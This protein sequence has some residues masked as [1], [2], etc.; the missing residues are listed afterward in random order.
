MG[1][2]FESVCEPILQILLLSNFFIVA[3]GVPGNITF[4]LGKHKT[5]ALWQTAEACVSLVL[6]I[7]LVAVFQLGLHGVAWG[8][9]L[10]N[11]VTQGLLWP[12]FITR[13]VGYP[14]SRYLIQTWGRP[15]LATIPFAVVCY[16]TDQLWAPQNLLAFSLQIFATLPFYALGVLAVF[17][18]DIR[19]QWITPDSLLRRRLVSPLLGR[20][21]ALG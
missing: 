16:W 7:V 10:P 15:A 1:A 13:L 2:E 17:H 9:T 8:L 6:T 20:K 21:G 11:M 3:N 19:Q 14:F 18:S 12:V 4:G 5:F